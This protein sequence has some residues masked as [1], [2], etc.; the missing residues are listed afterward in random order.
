MRSSLEG[1]WLAFADDPS[2]ASVAMVQ[3]DRGAFYEAHHP[4]ARGPV[5]R[6]FYFRAASVAFDRITARTNATDVRLLHPTGY[7]WPPQLT[8]SFFDGLARRADAGGLGVERVWIQTGDCGLRDTSVLADAVDAL[9][10]ELDEHTGPRPIR[11][12]SVARLAATEAFGI[13]RIDDVELLKVNVTDWSVA[14]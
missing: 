8:E 5:W 12:A 10:R 9:N 6:D 7:G 3:T 13:D 1:Q 2:G 14:G 11:D 4:N